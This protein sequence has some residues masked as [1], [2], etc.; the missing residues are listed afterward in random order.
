MLLGTT[1]E[2]FADGDDLT[3]ATSGNTGMTIRSGT[4]SYS[5]IFFSDATSGGGDYD[6]FI[7]Y[8]HDTKKLTIG[9]GAT[10]SSD[11]A[12]DSSGNLS[13]G[14]TTTNTSDKFT[15]VDAGDTFASIR[16]DTEA[17]DRYQ[18][19]DFAYGTDN[20]SSSNMTASIGAKTH[21]QSGGTLKADL[22][23]STNGGD[24]VTQKM[25]IKDDGKVGINQTTPRS[26]L[27]LGVGTHGA[28]TNNASEY[29]LGLHA[30]QG[31]TNDIG[32][33]IGFI[34]NSVGT[35][36]A[37]I[38]SYD[39]GG[40][41][42][43]G[44]AFF[45]GNSST[46]TQRAVIDSSGQLLLNETAAGGTCRLGMSFGNATGNYM[47]L[48]GTQ[49]S[50]NGLS[51]IFVFRHGY[52]GGSK[53]VASIGVD[54]TSSTG[55]SGR[56]LG[57]LV[58]HTGTSGNGDSASDSQQRLKITHGGDFLFNRTTNITGETFTFTSTQGNM[59]AIHQEENS[60]VIGMYL[61]HGYAASGQNGKMLSFRRNDG[62]EVG[63]I[64]IGNGS[65]S[66]NGDSDYRLKEN[67]VAISDGITRLKTLKPY[68]FN[69]KDD[70][71]YK[72][73]GFFAHEV[74]TAVP[75]AVQGVKD[76]VNEDGSIKAQQ[77]DQTK[78]IPLLTAALKEA[79]TK[80]ETLETKVAALEA[81]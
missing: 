30:A 49:R 74:S 81:A 50:A 75:E 69:F 27:D 46:L 28:L 67:E 19:L 1:T 56:G 13:L 2:G 53:E 45:T 33:N 32:K 38:N 18:V 65:I 17:D 14:T 26:L 43:T 71:D 48:G 7:Q 25:I 54:T 37:A 78:L 79:I 72:F 70:P 23:F 6:G 39:Y 76:A 9:T 44:L 16:S 55:G 21:S 62:T 77:I 61:R 59:M 58:F 68:K 36:T 35:V 51:K 80:I 52:W 57:A 15:I 34:S 5:S 3:I 73:D 63:S 66:V 11:L 10:G 64:T 60:D 24:S 12:I 41:D 20:R 40:S 42:Q 22:A 29:Q 31:S 8:N 47:E 4:T